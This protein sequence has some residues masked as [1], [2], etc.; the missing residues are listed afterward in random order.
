MST[1]LQHALGLLVREAV[2]APTGEEAGHWLSITSNVHDIAVMRDASATGGRLHHLAFWLD[3]RERVMRG[4]DLLV[5]SDARIEAG[6]GKHGVTQA[7]FLY[8]FEPS[9]NRIEVF[10]SGYQIFEPGWEPIL[11]TTEDKDRV[12]IAMTGFRIR[13]YVAEMARPVG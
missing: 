2:Q 9:G 1:F 8:F 12:E 3:T 11:W 13:D 10:S 7:F 5:E 6:P 4:A